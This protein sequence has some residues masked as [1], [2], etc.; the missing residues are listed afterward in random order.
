MSV[1][2]KNLR[3]FLK[4]LANVS[5][6]YKQKEKAK[7]DLEKH[8]EQLKADAMEKRSRKK[9]QEG[10]DKLN[11]KISTVLEKESEILSMRGADIA[12]VKDLM[13]KVEE[14]ESKMVQVENK[15]DE[16]KQKIE[17]INDIK[18]Q[19]E[20]RI[21]ELEKKIQK[22]AKK[23]EVIPGLS[24][25]LAELEARFEKMKASGKYDIS[26]LDKMKFKLDALR[27]KATIAGN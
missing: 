20:Q 18:I 11:E 3:R 14:T 6:K 26:V 4:H 1:N 7:E 25:K 23:R 2:P 10:F 17:S 9:I 13:K 27:L 21:I 5:V 19:R 12:K 8:V 16:L 24:D 15:C 22:S